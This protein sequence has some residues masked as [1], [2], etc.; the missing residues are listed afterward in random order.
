MA[1]CSLGGPPLRAARGAESWGPWDEAG[2]ADLAVGSAVPHRLG[3][4]VLPPHRSQ[5]TWGSV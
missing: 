1:A 3:M 5:R 4:T 2:G